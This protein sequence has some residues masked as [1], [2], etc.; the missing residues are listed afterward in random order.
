VSTPTDPTGEGYWV[1]Q[2]MG[3]GQ[4]PV[5]IAHSLLGSVEY[6][7]NL[8]QSLYRQYLGR[9][10]DAPGISSWVDAMGRG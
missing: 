9:G 2:V 7:S 6:R 1:G 5:A 10:G 4:G 3:A 8:A